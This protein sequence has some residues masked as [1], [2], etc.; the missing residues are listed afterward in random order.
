[1][2]S[3]ARESKIQCK[4]WLMERMLKI[5][6]DPTPFPEHKYE[7]SPIFVNPVYIKPLKAIVMTKCTFLGVFWTGHQHTLAEIREI[8]YSKKEGEEGKPVSTVDF[9][10]II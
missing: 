4:E 3:E 9:K 2:L 8:T 7:G 6:S 5:M 10:L 1:M